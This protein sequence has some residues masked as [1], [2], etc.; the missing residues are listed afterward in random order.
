MRGHFQRII[1]EITTHYSSDFPSPYLAE[2][3]S[4]IQCHLESALLFVSCF[5]SNVGILEAEIK[6]LKTA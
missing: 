1:T 6:T 4:V 3:Q 5:V 2:R